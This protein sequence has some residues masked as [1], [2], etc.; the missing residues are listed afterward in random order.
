[1]VAMKPHRIK[2]FTDFAILKSLSY[3]A[4]LCTVKAFQIPKK[5]LFPFYF[6]CNLKNIN[7]KVI[8]MYELAWISLNMLV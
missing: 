6:L 5:L 7:K 8:W 2:S 4:F 1:M 3:L